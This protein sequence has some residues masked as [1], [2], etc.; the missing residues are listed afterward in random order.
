MK[1]VVAAVAL[2]S[3]LTLAL[4]FHAGRV[5]ERNRGTTL[6]SPEHYGEDDSGTH[7][8]TPVEAGVQTDF[9]GRRYG[10]NAHAK[11]YVPP[12]YKYPSHLQRGIDE[13]LLESGELN[14]HAQEY[15]PPA[16]GESGNA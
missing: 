16:Q 11:E 4:A 8:N 5:H 14:A 1:L 9:E 2:V 10:L 12:H 15:V 3:A 7:E 6:D 13:I